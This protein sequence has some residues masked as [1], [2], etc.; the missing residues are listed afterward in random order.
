MVLLPSEWHDAYIAGVFTEFQ[1]QRAPGHT[2]LG[3]KIYHKGMLDIIDDIRDAEVALD[4]L[5]DTSAVSK[6]EELKAMRITAR[7]IIAYAER[8]A[9]ELQKS[10]RPELKSFT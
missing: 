6:H 9:D 3:D 2:V 5:N 7:T 10:A 4:F 8:H 1:E